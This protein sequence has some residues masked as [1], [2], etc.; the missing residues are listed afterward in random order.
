MPALTKRWEVPSL[1]KRREMTAL[2]KKKHFVTPTNGRRSFL[3]N[4]RAYV[5]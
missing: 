2:A 3:N 4:I 1:T 5:I